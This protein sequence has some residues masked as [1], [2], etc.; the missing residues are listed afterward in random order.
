MV[1]TKPKTIGILGLSYKPGTN[2]I[3]ESQGIALATGLIKKGFQ[4]VVYDP[5]ALF[6]LVVMQTVVGNI[7]KC[8]MVVKGGLDKTHSGQT[9][10]NWERQ[11]F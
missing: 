2:V 3:E 7:R 8:A 6:F 4:V 5:M 10:Q 1:E 9:V 11:Q